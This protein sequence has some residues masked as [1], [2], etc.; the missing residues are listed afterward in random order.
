MPPE[1][2]ARITHAAVPQ[3]K[4]NRS[5]KRLASFILPNFPAPK[6]CPIKGISTDESAIDPIIAIDSMRVPTPKAATVASPRS[7]A[8]RVKTA[9]ENGKRSWVTMAGI[10]I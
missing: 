2:S 9:F 8:I 3:T 5:E 6:F 7:A 4:A 10:P 1:K